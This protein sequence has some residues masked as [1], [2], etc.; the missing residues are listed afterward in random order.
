MSTTNIHPA[1][2]AQLKKGFPIEECPKCH[3]D[4]EDCEVCAGSGVFIQRV[5]ENWQP[6]ELRPGEWLAAYLDINEWCGIGVLNNRGDFTETEF[7]FES[8]GFA[9]AT[10][11]QT[12]GF[13]VEW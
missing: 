4:D 1:R 10:H 5:D 12:L 6:P 13:K 7:P 8:T 9:T 2:L 11:M 3:G